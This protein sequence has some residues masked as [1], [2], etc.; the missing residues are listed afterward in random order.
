[1]MR[2]CLT[3]LPLLVLL[4]F[5]HETG[6]AQKAFYA[7]NAV[8]W[9]KSAPPYDDDLYH[10]ILLLGDFK[11][12]SKNS[13]ALGLLK[14]KL[15]ALP[16]QSSLILLGDLV[17][18]NGLP[19]I[20][21]DDYSAAKA[22]LDR[23]LSH[24]KDYP[25]N[26]IFVPG[27]HDWDEGGK[28]GW[29]NVINEQK[30][31]QSAIN[32]PSVYLP[33]NGCPG[34][35]EASLSDDIVAIIFDSQWWFHNHEK[36]GTEDGCGFEDISGLLIQIEDI[37]RR[38]EG[39]KIIF[40]AHHPLF[41]VGNHAG[42]FHPSRLLFPLLD[43][44]E[45]LFLPLP[46][47][48]YTGYRRYLGSSQ[49][50]AHPEYKNYK[51]TLLNIFKD[52]PNII[53]AAGHEHNLQYYKHHGLHHIVSGGGGESTYV[54]GKKDKTDFAIESTG[55]SI[56][57]FYQ[58]GDVWAEFWAT[59]EADGE[60][61]F[62]QKL[63][64]QKLSDVAEIEMSRSHLFA[65]STIR[66]NITDNYEK[67][68][69]A[70]FWI[71]DG[72]RDVW[73][74]EVTLPVFDIRSEHGGLNILKRGGGMQ[75]RSIR[76]ENN[77][78]K[79]YVLRSANKF[80]GKLLSK[81]FQQTVAEDVLQDAISS[82]HPYGAVTI[83]VLA[84]AAGLM[85]TNP[86]MVWVPDDPAL[87]IYR[88]D[89]ANNV[90]LYEERPA[91][92]REDV[93]SFAH[94]EKIVNTPKTIEK[95]QEEHD[96]IVD[97]NMVVRA[98]LF[99]ILLGDWDRHDDQW[100]WATFEE[101]DVTIYRPV[102]RDRDQVY[103]VSKGLALRIVSMDFL[104]PKFQGF[105]YRI[106]NVNGFSYNA[107]HFDKTF[108]TEPDR[109]VW[110]QTAAFLQKAVT[111]SVIHEAMLEL[112]EEIYALSGQ[113]IESKIQ[114]RRKD[115][116]EYADEYYHYLAEAVDVVGTDERDFFKV[117]RL[118]NGNSD[119]TVFAMSDKKGKIKEQIYHREF[120][121]DETKEIRLYGLKGEDR[122]EVEGSASK[123]IKV[124][125]IGGKNKDNFID[126]SVVHGYSKNVFVYDRK[127]KKNDVHKGLETKLKLSADKSVNEYNRT[128]FRPNHTMPLIS[129][130]YNIDD[131]VFIVG[132]V[133]IK[134]FNF[135][136]S[137]FHKITGSYAFETGAF[138]IE[139]NGLY[140]AF[141]DHFDLELPASFSMPRN[142]DNFFGLGNETERV[143]DEEKFYRVRYEHGSLN[144][145]LKHS[146][147][148][149]I[150]YKLGLFYHFYELEDTKDRFISDPEVN[151]LDDA[152]YDEHH[153]AGL[154]LE[155]EIDTRN[156]T[157][158][159]KRGLVWQSKAAGFFGLNNDSDHFVRLKSDL[160]FYVSLTADPRA[161]VALRFGG[162]ANLG[163][164][165]FFHANALGRKSNLRGFVSRRFS[166]DHSVYQNTE[167]R[168][169]LFN[170]KSRFFKGQTGFFLF[171]DVGRVWL[172]GEESERWHDGYGAGLWFTPFEFTAA[173][174][175]Y[176]RSYD[177]SMIA[178]NLNFLY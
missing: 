76:M 89:L 83:P 100:R 148:D 120:K 159:P 126:T 143:T 37:I 161:V 50:L 176:N 64:T 104:M 6:F 35:V 22:D 91:G 88:K 153:F 137:T 24:V 44:N 114:S 11:N 150:N 128:Q 87:G 13:H 62:R 108:M 151:K 160:S 131:E 15:S 97:Q 23:V 157:V 47:F 10:S 144:P 31:I 112:P 8:D 162:A 168:F 142:V 36:P 124:R 122:F 51:E 119:V 7:P 103:Y 12:P 52:Y 19:S 154:N 1:M 129:G 42:Y 39:K 140:S 111:D 115:L 90:Y 93:A 43:V 130:G 79:Q 4:L 101:N 14:S 109:D 57:N 173:T 163:D 26:I 59:N 67:G 139:Y 117:K 17:Y 86:K 177:D 149:K 75:S 96:H 61:V 98:R 30:Y 69:F 127:D 72:Y 73:G 29:E 46:G 123:A 106:R 56:L 54:A 121:Q 60:L 110:M 147:S 171:N 3:S 41:S 81:E 55:L 34:P 118:E 53:Y 170:V 74:Q 174:F 28:E 138:N 145:M 132:G 94:S 169:K 71:G 152:A 32:R 40:A 80:A 105:D 165:E 166:G 116:L 78:G 164:Y 38:N 82:S 77:N 155:F 27:G 175:S 172:K 85:H 178:F 66:A 25:G 58:N 63:Y 20:D 70:R 33:E 102:P 95:T 107:R 92:N 21:S 18:P 158:F 68:L 156:S 48:L 134:R 146:V 84:D 125:L 113:E 45:N 136:D 135:R 2:T 9:Q 65:D 167:F 141:S 16:E 5:L 99:D 49:D 133:H